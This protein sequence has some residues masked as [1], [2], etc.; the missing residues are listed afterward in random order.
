SKYRTGTWLYDVSGWSHRGL[1][2]TLSVRRFGQAA[3]GGRVTD[4]RGQ[5]VSISQTQATRG[6][7]RNGVDFSNHEVGRGIPGRIRVGDHTLRNAPGGWH[8]WA[9][10]AGFDRDCRQFVR[11][12]LRVAR[13]I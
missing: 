11:N 9:A 10:C 13:R 4:L 6:E 8:R 2:R 3:F 7:A 1:R 12:D 5:Y